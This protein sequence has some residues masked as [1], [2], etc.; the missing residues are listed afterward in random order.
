M[1]TR[2]LILPK[3]NP[4]ASLALLLTLLFSYRRN[5]SV[6]PQIERLRIRALRLDLAVIAKEILQ[7]VCVVLVAEHEVDHVVVDM[8]RHD[9]V[10]R[11]GDVYLRDLLCERP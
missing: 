2:V 9:Q 1:T 8:F 11:V 4:T 10:V 3:S 5:R 7:P 6:D